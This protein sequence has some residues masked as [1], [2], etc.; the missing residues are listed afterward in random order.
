MED[1]QDARRILEQERAGVEVKDSEAFAEQ[2]LFFL[3]HQEE[4]QEAGR[5]ARP[6]AAFAPAANTFPSSKGGVTSS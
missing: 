3:N 6:R 1:F 2:A 5:R 4:L